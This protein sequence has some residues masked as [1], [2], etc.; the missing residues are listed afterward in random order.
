M[1]ISPCSRP[2][3]PAA[4]RTLRQ[5]GVRLGFLSNFTP[6]MLD[7]ALRKSGL[8]DM[9]RHVLSTDRTRT[10]KPNPRAYQL[11]VD[12]LGLPRD[13]IVFAA[14]AGWDAVGAKRFGYPTF[15]VNRMQAPPEELGVRP[16]AS[17]PPLAELIAFV[18]PAR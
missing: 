12:A 2:E 6:V 5:A 8:A 16:D 3:V 13:Q 15:W 14:F 1:R 11:G 7:T 4:L 9:F 10:F 18:T 17:G